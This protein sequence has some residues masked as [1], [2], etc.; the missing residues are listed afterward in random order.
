MVKYLTTNTCIKHMFY[1]L[2][3]THHFNVWIHLLAALVFFLKF[4]KIITLFSRH[5]LITNAS[6]TVNVSIYLACTIICLLLINKF[7]CQLAHD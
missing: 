4:T 7:I 3:L 2:S 5:V 6:I 1:C